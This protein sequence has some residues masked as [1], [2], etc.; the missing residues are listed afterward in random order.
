MSESTAV[1]LHPRHGTDRRA[2]GTPRWPVAAVA[3]LF[4]LPFADLMFRAQEVHRAHHPANAVQLSTL[5]SV[6]TGGCPED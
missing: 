1:T 3:D 2:D 6:K 4:A 5:V